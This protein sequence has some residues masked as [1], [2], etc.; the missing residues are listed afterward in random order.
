MNFQNVDLPVLA[1]F[2]SEITGKNFV[3]NEN[4]VPE[5]LQSTQVVVVGL[6]VMSSFYDPNPILG[7]VELKVQCRHNLSY[8]FI[9]ER[10]YVPQGTVVVLGPYVIPGGRIHQLGRDPTWLS[11]LRTLPSSTYLT[12]KSRLTSCTFTALLL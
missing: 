5:E 10:K 4:G 1:K 2:I 12:P 9:L 3:L 11:A 8:D 7:Q 6:K